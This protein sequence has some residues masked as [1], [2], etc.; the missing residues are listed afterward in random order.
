MP[1]I[2]P[3]LILEA[4][5]QPNYGG[6]AGYFVDPE[7][8]LWRVGFRHGFRSARVY[9]G[10]GYKRGP[11]YRIVLYDRGNYE[12]RKL[13][14]APGYYPD[15]LDV[16][17]QHTGRFRS[18]N[19][20]PDYSISGPEWGSIP[21]IVQLFND[22]DYRGRHATVLRDVPNTHS[23]LGM[24]D[25]ISSVRVIK[26]SD[27]P[28]QGAKVRLYEHLDYGG[29]Y[30]EIAMTTYDMKKEIP[31][32]SMLPMV[33]GQYAS[34]FGN[35][36]SSVQVEGWASSGEFM[37][38]AY[39]DEFDQA[40]MNE[41]WQWVDPAGGGEWRERQGYLELRADPGQDLW[42]G[43]PPGSGGDMDAPRILMEYSGD[44][45]IETRLPV[46]PQ[47]REHGGL[48]V[49]KSPGRF[50]R[51]EKTSGAHGFA[52]AVRFERHVNRVFRLVGRGPNNLIRTRH[53]YL[54]LERRRNQ[55]TGFAS[56]DG[57]TW[58]NCGV[59]NVGMGDP[60]QIGLHGLCPGN[61]PPTITRFDYFRVFA[62]KGEAVQLRLRPQEVTLDEQQADAQR[63]AALRRFMDA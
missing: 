62:R 21:V 47:L 1:A 53:L 54:R 27:F 24:A 22:P 13:V 30:L 52:G 35:A 28:P 55:F 56:Q 3:R 38:M 33:G 32:L 34:T 12:G 25:T 36:I 7:P 5:E 39:N 2:N 23:E 59:T 61:I 8:S 31:D 20:A 46:T 18:F 44:F 10:P 50:L 40:G 15:L 17:V 49:W 48:L 57:Q 41:V 60:V 42:H 14:L 26:G 9:R 58:V 4:Y 6:V 29:P 19:I 43:N 51:L 63:I 45:A 37:E 16:S 11:N